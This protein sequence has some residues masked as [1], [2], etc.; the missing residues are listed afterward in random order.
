[1]QDMRVGDA[2]VEKNAKMAL[3][4]L[5]VVRTKNLIEHNFFHFEHFTFKKFVQVDGQLVVSGVALDV[6]RRRL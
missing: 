1:M 3:M 4:S 2:T 5:L 6:L